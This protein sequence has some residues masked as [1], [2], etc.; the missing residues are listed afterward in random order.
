MMEQL[1][2][3]GHAVLPGLFAPAEVADLRDE[4]T[5][6]LR[7]PGAVGAMATAAGLYGARN[8]LELFPRAATLWRRPPLTEVLAEVL[9][10]RFGLVRVLFFDKPPEQ[11]WALPWHKD[12]AIAVRE[13]HLPSERFSRPTTKA[14]VPHVEAPLE[15]LE[16]ML[17]VRLHLDDVTDE[18]GPLRVFPGSHRSGK[19]EQLAGNPV[20][21]H[22]AAG[23]ALLMRPLLLHCSNRSHPA[24]TR[25]RRILHFEF[26]ASPELPDGYEWHTF[27]AHDPPVAH[28][29][30]SPT[31]PSLV[32]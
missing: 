5:A 28:A 2:F 6:A 12:W 19:E 14:G 15:V 7:R 26:A 1:K 20:T 18:N 29:P 23:D 3:A 27:V 30:A 13:N 22:A 11:T 32:R 8:V 9:G 4:L 21:I 25:H 31:P 17:T 10:G 24:T 16:A